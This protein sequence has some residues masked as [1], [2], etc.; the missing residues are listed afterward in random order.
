M[1]CTAC[2]TQIPVGGRY[3]PQCGR[4]EDGSKP[5]LPPPQISSADRPHPIDNLIAGPIMTAQRVSPSLRAARKGSS[6]PDDITWVAFWWWIFA[7]VVLGFAEGAYWT[8]GE[9]YAYTVGGLLGNMLFPLIIALMFAGLKYIFS[10]KGVRRTIVGAWIIGFV[11]LLFGDLQNS[12]VTAEQPSKVSA[13]LNN[14]R[15]AADGN[16]AVNQTVGPRATFET[17]DD[18]EARVMNQIAVSATQMRASTRETQ[19]EMDQL[20]VNPILNAKNLVTVEG[21]ESGRQLLSKYSDL[22][23]KY[24]GAYRTY[25]TQA[26]AALQTLPTQDRNAAFA[27]FNESKTKATATV[28]GYINVERDLVVTIGQVLDLAQSNVGVSQVRGNE[29]LLPETALNQYRQLFQR[30]SNDAT[31]EENARKNLLDMAATEDAAI[32]KAQRYFSDHP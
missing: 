11:L 22:L 5:P 15:S 10:K 3:C 13:A 18:S 14:L 7:L 12:R 32:S 31:A 30:I 19:S 8:H 26:A 21:I 27:K 23:D 4:P 6:A 17:T 9:F 25:L 28:E 16:G 29:I 24:D 1:Y 2:G 20:S